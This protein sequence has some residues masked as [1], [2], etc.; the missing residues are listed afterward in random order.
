MRSLL[1]YHVDYNKYLR[2]RYTL[3]F[4]L[5]NVSFVSYGKVILLQNLFEKKWILLT[6]SKKWKFQKKLQ[7]TNLLWFCMKYDNRY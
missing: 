1:Q 4:L 7:K 3:S 5:A 6:T 2:G